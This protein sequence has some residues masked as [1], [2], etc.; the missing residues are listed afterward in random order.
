MKLKM[1]IEKAFGSG[2]LGLTT[3]RIFDGEG[4][5]VYEVTESNEVISDYAHNTLDF[6]LRILGLT[7]SAV[8]PSIFGGVL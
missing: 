2:K 1:E 3:V 8:Q 5:I 4:V 6:A 7:S